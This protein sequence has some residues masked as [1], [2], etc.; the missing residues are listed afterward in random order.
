VSG[1]A[2]AHSTHPEEPAV[3]SEAAVRF[4]A[5][6]N[7]FLAPERRFVTSTVAF[8]EPHS[9]GDLIRSLGVPLENVDLILVDGASVSPDAPIR[10]G[11][12]IAVYPQFESFDIADTQKMREAPL[13]VPRFV[14]DVHLGKLATLLRMAGFDAK[15]RNDF[16]DCELK[17]I[18]R[19]E[20]RLLFSCDRKLVDES[21]LDRAYR[22]RADSPVEQ[23]AEV[24]ERF[25][26]QKLIRPFTRCMLCNALL[27]RADEDSVRS[28]VP[29]RVWQSQTEF[30]RC[31]ACGRVYW[32]G[33]HVARMN[34][35]LDRV[36]SRESRPNAERPLNIDFE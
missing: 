6:L 23:F 10:N 5:E 28:Q 8:G 14:L 21:A 33:T 26:L 9:T 30:R 22:I 15:Y 13:R 1:P 2:I 3:M 31:P 36:L 29:P 34:A 24:L 7:D 11:V 16:S 12:R 18:S 32:P 19:D 27:V 20:E 4:Y 25:Q 35:L 17:E